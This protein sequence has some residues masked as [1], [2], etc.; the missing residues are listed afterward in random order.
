MMFKETVIRRL[1]KNIIYS[2]IV[3]ELDIEH[4]RAAG[5]LQP[6]WK[7][8]CTTNVKKKLFGEFVTI[9]CLPKLHYMID[10]LIVRPIVCYVMMELKIV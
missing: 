6:L 3:R 5:N 4:H 2:P 8:K 9:A 1:E 10:V 7:I